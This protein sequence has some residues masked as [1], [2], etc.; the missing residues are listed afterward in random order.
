MR[1][2]LGYTPC[3]LPESR[4]NQSS[5]GVVP[6]LGALA[7]QLLETSTVGFHALPGFL[8]EAPHKSKQSWSYHG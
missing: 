6:R 4:Q 2:T 3:Q 5:K 8:G 1:A 7:R